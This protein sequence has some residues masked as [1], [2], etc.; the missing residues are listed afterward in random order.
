MN[1]IKGKAWNQHLVEHDVLNVP[2]MDL[3]SGVTHRWTKIYKLEGYYFTF[4]RP[5][6]YKNLGALKS[7]IGK[8]LA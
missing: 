8:G 6:G 5:A 1:V 7:L 2:E 3:Y 4:N